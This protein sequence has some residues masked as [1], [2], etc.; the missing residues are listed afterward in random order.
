MERATV[1]G[2]W[3][4]EFCLIMPSEAGAAM[5]FPPI[6]SAAFVNDVELDRQ[7]GLFSMKSGIRRF[8]YRHRRD[9]R[10]QSLIASPVEPAGR[11]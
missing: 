3:W 4:L 7:K 5:S 6:T 1:S 8:K 10:R 11:R 2:L 9:H